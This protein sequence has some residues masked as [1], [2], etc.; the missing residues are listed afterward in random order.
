AQFASRIA[1][2][3]VGS[4]VQLSRRD[5]SAQNRSPHIAVASLLLAMDADVIA[6]HIIWN[7]FRNSRRQVEFKPR[8]QFAKKVLGC[9]AVLQEEKLQAGALTVFP[10]HIAVFKNGSD[11]FQ[12]RQ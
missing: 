7:I 2:S 10:Q 1:L 12:Y 11:A 8:F 4:S 9:P 5:P 3:Q 6:V